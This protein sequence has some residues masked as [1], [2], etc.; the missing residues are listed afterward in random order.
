[1]GSPLRLTLGS[2]TAAR[3][4][5]GRALAIVVDEFERAEQAMSR[6]RETSEITSLQPGGR[7]GRRRASP[8]HR[9]AAGAR[10]PPI[11]ARR[12]TGGRFD[13]RVLVDLDRLGYRGARPRPSRRPTPRRPPVGRSSIRAGVDEPDR[14]ASGRSRRDRQGSR[15]AL[16]RRPT[17]RTGA[18]RLPARGRRRSR[19][20]GARPRRRPLAGRH[21]GSGR[22]R[23]PG[24]HRRRRP[25]RSRR[26]RSGSTAGSWTAGSSTTSL[27]PRTGEPADDRPLAVTVARTGPRLGRGLVQGPLP[28]RPRGDRERGAS[29]R[30][31]RHGGSPTT[32]RSR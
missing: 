25:R 17:R 31:G 7:H 20:T 23:R 1:M 21:R 5:G 13:P 18:R 22:R 11:G 8:S 30:S 16:G 15:P 27:D 24:R 29:A 6:F 26:R 28:R 12:I 9:A 19:R 32:G 3:D 10:R 4:D 14:R 2:G